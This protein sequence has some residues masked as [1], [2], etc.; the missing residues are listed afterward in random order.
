MALATSF[1]AAIAFIGWKYVA[2]DCYTDLTSYAPSTAEVT[3][4]FDSSSGITTLRE[5]I[6]TIISSDKMIPNSFECLA[7]ND[8]QAKGKICN[9]DHEC[10]DATNVD[11]ECVNDYDCGDV[12]KSACGVSTST[13][14]NDL[15]IDNCISRNQCPNGLDCIGGRCQ[16][17]EE[18]SWL[19]FPQTFYNVNC[20]ATAFSNQFNCTMQYTV[21]E[22]VNSTGDTATLL[23]DAGSVEFLLQELNARFFTANVDFVSTNNTNYNKSDLHGVIISHDDIIT[24]NGQKPDNEKPDDDASGEGSGEGSGE[25]S[26]DLSTLF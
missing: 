17:H 10:V 2:G 18:T 4:T 11:V 5:D 24:I 3:I 15:G 21:P 25:I 9:K 22:N 12:T 7:P 16:N 26:D 20:E 23:S 8:C 6:A 14:A 1:Y 19:A 13:C